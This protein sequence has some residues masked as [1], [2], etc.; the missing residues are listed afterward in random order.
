MRR[1]VNHLMLIIALLGIGVKGW[2]LVREYRAGHNFTEAGYF[3]LLW[4]LLCLVMAGVAVFSIR[5]D[6]DAQK[7]ASGAQTERAALLALVDR[8]AD[9][10]NIA[11]ARRPIFAALRAVLFTV[12]FL[13]I[14]VILLLLSIGG[15]LSAWGASHWALLAV[16]ELPVLLAVGA[17]AGRSIR[18]SPNKSL[19]R[20]RGA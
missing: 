10:W 3:D 19:E 12:L 17:I 1:L 18:R 5:Q 7:P 15:N 9:N 6:P 13:A 20:T 4:V 16:A 8:A 11:F 14:P 2:A